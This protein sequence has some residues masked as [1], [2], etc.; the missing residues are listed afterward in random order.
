M[1]KRAKKPVPKEPEPSGS[2]LT[3]S[4]V[5]TPNPYNQYLVRAVTGPDDLYGRQLCT[6]ADHR[7]DGQWR[8]TE[9][10]PT[11][12]SEDV[13]FLR[14]TSREA[15]AGFFLALHRRV[16]EINKSRPLP[17]DVTQYLKDR[18]RHLSDEEHE[19]LMT[20]QRVRGERYD[21][22]RFAR[23]NQLPDLVWRTEDSDPERVVRNLLSFTVHGL[24]E[25]REVPF[26]SETNLYPLLGKEDARTLRSRLGAVCRRVAANI[27]EEL[28]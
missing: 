20:L 18:A 5:Q 15:A 13:R 6:V 19:A 12:Y 1:A 17:E 4:P 26:F 28:L 2:R 27:T 23:R 3:F 14:F 21:L 8:I 7:G 16:E 10:T 9:T 11:E 22:L 24:E 25:G